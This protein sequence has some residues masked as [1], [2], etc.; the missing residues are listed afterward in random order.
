MADDLLLAH[1]NEKQAA[2]VSAPRRPLLLLAGPGTGKT[3]TLIYRIIYNLK[4]FKIPPDQILALTFSNKAAAEIKQRLFEVIPDKADKIR[5]STFHSFC[6]DILR[7]YPDESGLNKHFAVCDQEYQERLLCRLLETR[8]RDNPQKKVKGILLAFSNYLLKGRALPAFSSG[9]YEEYALHLNRHNLVDFDQIIV[10]THWLLENSKDILEQYRFMNSAVMVDEFQDTD[11]VQYEVVHLLASKHGNIFT[12]ADDDQSIYAWR[13]ANPDNIRKYMQDFSID[14]PVFLEQNYRSGEKIMETA[15]NLIK[16]TDRVE[17]D[18]IINGNPHQNAVLKAVFFRNERDEI[19]FIINKIKHWQNNDHA[20]NSDIA[21][22]YP[23]HIFGD[24]VSNYL[25]KER[26]P[27]QQAAGRNLSEHPVMKKIL[28]YLKLIRDPSDNLIVEELA[29][30]ELGYHLYKQIQN[31]STLKRISFRKAL[32]LAS[33]Q[34]EISYNLRNQLNTFIGNTA[35]LVNLK[36]FFNF[37]QL[38]GEI[39]QGIQNLVPTAL[40]KYAS[41]FKP[42]FFKK[43]PVRTKPGARI[44]F[45]HPDEKIRY[46]GVRLLKNSFD[47]EIVSLTSEKIIH[48]KKNDLVLLSGPLKTEGLPCPFITLFKEKNEYREGMLTILFRWIQRQLKEENAVF[49][50]YVVFDLETTGKD[51]DSCGIVE[52]AAARA[53]NGRIEDTFH[54]MINP[55]MPIEPEASNV[56][57][58]TDADVKDSPSISGIWKEFKDFVGDNLLIA[59]NGFAF[60]FKIIDRTAKEI[61]E[62]K[63]QNLRYD[64]LILARNLFHGQQNSIDGLAAR[65]KLDAGTRHRAADD[66]K[67]LHDIFQKLLAVQERN[68]TNS[69]GEDLCEFASL[70]NVLENSLAAAEDKILFQA[71][72][73]KL[74]SPY[75]AVRQNYCA[76]FSIDDEELLQ[77]LIRIASKVSPA[78]A[79]YSTD[80]D[81]YR[82]V[83]Q[84]AAEFS[85]LQVDL[86]VPEFL[87]YV[88]LV[89]PQDSLDKIDAVSLLTFHAAKG[90]EFDKVIIL[91]MEDEQMPSFFAYRNDDQ[92]DRSV[93]KKIEEQKRLLYVGITRGKNEILFTI[94]ENRSGRK[95]KSSPFLEQ[96]RSTIEIESPS[97]HSLL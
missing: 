83:M 27:F 5:C 31:I 8:M 34:P 92:D 21:L 19:N 39:I 11:P 51:P 52:I 80:E 20:A 55:G 53:V 86:A 90:L 71:G 41:K 18:K 22:I 32:Y 33:T 30:S 93:S 84:T 49:K 73:K 70:G 88:S 14:K 10:K 64:S 45:Y 43:T 82:R 47:T 57:H 69:L 44:W 56:H 46:L 96:I 24:R 94:V 85:R 40:Q 17:P 26:I 87:S 63:L 91:G 50:S 68:E 61:G 89:N 78:S 72:I 37:E 13:G 66:V 62:Q 48:I 16:D 3:L 2:A 54:R 35:N 75:S 29:E 79:V 74:I 58:I 65:F 42:L 81:F 59:H 76:E 77:N 1:L 36:S 95:H 25:L 28:L 38:I 15:A 6:L 4:Y 97:E 12:A 7:K 67:V 9:L 23:R 60:D